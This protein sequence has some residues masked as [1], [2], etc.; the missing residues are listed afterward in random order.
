VGLTYLR[1]EVE[2]WGIGELVLDGDRVLHS[3]LPRASRS[4]A[5][6]AAASALVPAPS[7]LRRRP[8]G[9]GRDHPLVERLQRYFAGDRVDFSDVE[10]E[11]H[12]QTEF[13]R[14][15]GAAMRAIPY[16]EV[17]SYGELSLLAGRARA[18]RA[19]NFCA[20]CHFAPI[21]PVHRVVSVGGIGGFGSSGVE[22]KRRLLE[23]EGAAL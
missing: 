2:G 16:G 19:A 7:S 4:G 14:R 11:L 1:Y 22:V 18:A 23:L 3:E 21:V 6:E 15:L 9:A 8:G 20:R 10:V 5:G 17:V 12:D 13:G